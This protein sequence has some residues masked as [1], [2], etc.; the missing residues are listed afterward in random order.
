MASSE[1]TV[2]MISK[3]NQ[4]L[5]YFQAINLRSSTRRK[6]C[7]SRYATKKVKMISIAKKALTILSVIASPLIGDLRNPNSNGDTHAV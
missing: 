7:G 5:M 4:V 2:D 6:V 3:K 1:G